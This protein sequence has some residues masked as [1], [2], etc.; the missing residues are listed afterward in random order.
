M[1]VINL[2][3]DLQNFWNQA[4]QLPHLKRV[5]LWNSSI[6]KKNKKL[7]EEQ[8]WR[9]ASRENWESFKEEKLLETF[10]YYE[11]HFYNVM[12]LF[13]RFNIVLDEQCQKYKSIFSDSDFSK[14]PFYVMPSCMTFNGRGG[15]NTDYPNQSVMYMGID[16]LSK[17]N[18]DLDL[19]F[20]HELFHLYH[21]ERMKV[22]EK[23]FMTQGRLTLPLWLEGLAT[24]V[25]GEFCPNRTLPELLMDSNF[26]DVDESNVLKVSSKFKTVANEM[27]GHNEMKTYQSLF[28]FQ[29]TPFV[30]GLPPRVGY[31][32]G[33]FVVKEI[34]KSHELSDVVFW[35]HNRVHS[36]VLIILEKLV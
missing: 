7:F 29:T 28:N 26:E 5:E 8:V 13:D 35:D 21:I 23:V 20:S 1:I 34:L 12:E 19:F 16:Y 33:Y 25:S 24:Y 30:E 18:D 32:L 6:E 27:I 14:T 22:D 15:S 36:E 9:V 2:K 3:E 31:Y 11:T 17:R 10:S 4:A